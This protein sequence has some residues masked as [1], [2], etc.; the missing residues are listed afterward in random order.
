M[1]ENVGRRAMRRELER[2]GWRPVPTRQEWWGPGSALLPNML[3]AWI[4]MRL[5]A[6]APK[7]CTVQETTSEEDAT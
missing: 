4:E 5:L 6:P 1:R 3:S 7:S 2:A